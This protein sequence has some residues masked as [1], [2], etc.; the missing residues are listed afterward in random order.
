MDSKFFFLREVAWVQ[1]HK[2]N[3]ASANNK[4][5]ECQIASKLANLQDEC[6]KYDTDEDTKEVRTVLS[7]LI[8][9]SVSY[10]V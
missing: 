3:I 9:S 7:D 6:D 10:L 5:V 4:D 1:L 8:I 2:D